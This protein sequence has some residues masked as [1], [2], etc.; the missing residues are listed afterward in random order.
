MNIYT[1]FKPTYLYIK[2]HAITGKLYFGKTIKNPEKYTGSGLH[3]KRHIT[4]HGKEHIQTLWFCL[5][6]DKDSIVDF[7]LNFSEQQHIVESEEWLNQIIENAIDGGSTC[8][9]G[10]GAF[11]KKYKRTKPCSLEARLN[12][13]MCKKGKALSD[14]HKQSLSIAATGKP[15]SIKRSLA[16]SKFVKDA[17]PIKCPHCNKIGKLPGMNVWHFAHC[18][19]ANL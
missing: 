7:A 11:G 16:I 10:N 1:E 19:F 9:T 4:K 14:S 17:E 8:G 2:Q 5:F 12:M 13:S 6:Y 18:K 15:K 3:W